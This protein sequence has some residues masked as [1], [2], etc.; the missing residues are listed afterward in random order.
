M[1]LMRGRTAMAVQVLSEA[2]TLRYDSSFGQEDNELGRPCGMAIGPANVIYVADPGYGCVARFRE[3]GT[4]IDSFGKGEGGWFRKVGRV[5]NPTGVAVDGDGYTWVADVG[6]QRS[7]LG[8]AISKF[9]QDGRYVMTI[10]R[11]GTGEGEFDRPRSVKFDRDGCLWVVDAYN[12]RLQKFDA[13][14]RFLTV[15]GHRGS[16]PAGGGAFDDPSDLAFDERG[17]LWVT[18]TF[19]NRVQILEPE[20]RFVGQFGTGGSANGEFLRP[21]GIAID[22]GIAFV[23]DVV[24]HRVQAFDRDGRFLASFGSAGSGDGQFNQPYGVAVLGRELL[25]ADNQNRRIVRLGL[26]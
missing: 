24:G 13:A 1:A 4:F 9:D 8:N 2:V 20:G 19:N 25:V 15:L 10:G 21:R 5:R 3:D 6:A 11:K 17:Y 26:G 23:T 22:H 7:E 18:D 16:D 14:G 12:H